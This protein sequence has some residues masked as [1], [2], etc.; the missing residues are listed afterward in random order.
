[1]G[2][3]KTL[4]FTLVVA[5][6]AELAVSTFPLSSAPRDGDRAQLQL[7]WFKLWNT[8][9]MRESPTTPF[10]KPKAPA[11]LA[12][13]KSIGTAALASCA[14]STRRRVDRRIVQYLHETLGFDVLALEGSLTQA[15]LA[16]E[17][18]YRSSEPVARAMQ[19]S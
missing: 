11:A 6:A 1:M 18:L 9:E 14:R 10:K 2:A 15:W 17:Y 5:T 3:V 16:Q 12:P 7:A 19:R 4:G 8:V 13:A